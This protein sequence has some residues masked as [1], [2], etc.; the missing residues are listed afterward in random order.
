MD[1][2]STLKANKSLPYTTLTKATTADTSYSS[3]TSHA[4][5][6]S[7]PPYKSEPF[8]VPKTY[9]RLGFF[10][11]H[12]GLWRAM[13]CALA[14][15]VWSAQMIYFFFYFISLPA[16]ED[17]SWPVLSPTYA[18]WPFISCIGAIKEFSFRS[19]SIIVACLLWLGFGID[20]VVG[21]RSPVGKWWRRGKLATASV[22]NIFLI[23]LT[24]A[25]TDS[26]RKLHLTLT[27]FQILC[28]AQSKAC[29]W[30][31]ARNMREWTPN[32]IYLQRVKIWK[33]VAVVIAFPC[34]LVASAAIYGCTPGFKNGKVSYTPVCWSLTSFGAPA[35]WF[36]AWCWVLYVLTVSYDCYHLDYTVDFLLSTPPPPP[37]R[38]SGW[39][40]W[41]RWTEKG[42][43]FDKKMETW[44]T[45]TKTLVG[46][47]A[48][49]ATEGGTSRSQTETQTSNAGRHL[50]RSRSYPLAGI[51]G[52]DLDEEDISGRR[53]DDDADL[54]WLPPNIPQSVF[55]P[56]KYQKLDGSPRVGE[57]IDIR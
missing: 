36:L 41:R 27:S 16:L 23:A 35:E 43:S 50:Q 5:R 33:R 42:T 25:N 15:I 26:H 11:R 49:I 54:G 9:K 32:N 2:N 39:A 37:K 31:L 18:M 14:A 24:W 44:N 1:T 20:Y 6:S 40:F 56:G 30:N 8:R 22:S 47:A 48:P 45:S 38:S 34:W 28:M 55:G 12:A 17:G 13:P 7:T 51:F 53:Y 52:D 19:V 21:S 57:P 3:Y 46:A 4:S 29:D 10:R